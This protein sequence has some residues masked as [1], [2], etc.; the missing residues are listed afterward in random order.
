MNSYIN[1]AQQRVTAAHARLAHAYTALAQAQ[2]ADPPDLYQIAHC[3]QQVI[4]SE[5][6]LSRCERWLAWWETPRGS[7]GVST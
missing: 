1:V 6:W 7:R 3:E 5:I 2:Q 4:A